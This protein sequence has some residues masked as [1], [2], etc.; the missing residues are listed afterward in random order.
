MYIYLY[1]STFKGLKFWTVLLGVQQCKLTLNVTPGY[2]PGGIEWLYSAPWLWFSCITSDFICSLVPMC[3]CILNVFFLSVCVCE[4]VYES[5]IIFVFISQ[6]STLFMYI[7][8]YL[9]DIDRVT[10][11]GYVPTQQDV[12]RVRV[13]TTGIIEYPFDLENVIFRYP[14][15]HQDCSITG[16]RQHK[17]L[18]WIR[19]ETRKLKERTFTL[20]SQSKTRTLQVRR[21][22][23]VR[24]LWP[25]S[26]LWDFSPA[27]VG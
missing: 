13:P 21:D 20:L 16:A 23:L 9:S 27:N 17:P 7:S 11:E 19:V 26:K 24:L 10:A 15:K 18:M 3:V 6:L 1:D 4:K 14:Q 12:L 5:V 25:I 22:A 8:S 2:Q